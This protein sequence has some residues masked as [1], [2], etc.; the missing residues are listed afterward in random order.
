M[1]NLTISG[2]GA[3]P[4]K[5]GQEQSHQNSDGG[6]GP[7]CGRQQDQRAEK[8]DIPNEE[9]CL[10]AIAHSGFASIVAR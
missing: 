2:H 5:A 7:D 10:R 8:A 4:E 3:E 9:D 6:A 1:S